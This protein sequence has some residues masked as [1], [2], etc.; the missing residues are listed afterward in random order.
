MRLLDVLE[1]ACANMNPI[2]SK[3]REVGKARFKS[4]NPVIASDFFVL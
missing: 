4:L 1:K 3:G 2:D